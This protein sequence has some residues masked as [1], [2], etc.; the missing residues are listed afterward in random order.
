M[1]LA[2]A[3]GICLAISNFIHPSVIVIQLSILC[4]TLVGSGAVCLSRKKVAGRVGAEITGLAC[5]LIFIIGAG[6]QQI[7]LQQLQQHQVITDRQEISVLFKLVLGFNQDSNGSF[8]EIDYNQIRA[9]ASGAAGRGLPDLI[10]AA[11][12][13]SVVGCVVYAAKNR[14]CLVSAGRLFLL[15][16]GRCFA[17]IQSAGTERHLN[18]RTETAI[19]ASDGLDSGC[20]DTGYYFC[21]CGVLAGGDW[22]ALGQFLQR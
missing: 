10:A 13:G 21:A 20:A 7:G 19:L 17:G 8:S 14:Y 16:S 1:L 6:C 9:A 2:A 18:R 3:T 15:V 5:L 11:A 4:F 12:A 22:F